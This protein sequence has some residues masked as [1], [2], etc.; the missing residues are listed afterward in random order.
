MGDFNNNDTECPT[1]SKKIHDYMGELFEIDSFEFDFYIEKNIPEK[2]K[3][4]N[5]QKM[6]QEHISGDAYIDKLM[7]WS[8]QN[9]KK[10]PNK[11]MHFT[12]MRD[13]MY[14]GEFETTS[15]ILESLHSNVLEIGVN[16]RIEEFLNTYIGRFIDYIATTYLSLCNHT[17][18]PNFLDEYL[19]ELRKV[20]ASIINTWFTE[21]ENEF[22][23]CIEFII[24][25]MRLADEIIQSIDSRIE[26]Y[27]DLIKALDVKNFNG[28]NE[29]I[30]K[31][32]K[33]NIT[34][35]QI[36]VAK[37]MAYHILISV[38]FATL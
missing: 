23:G 25:K 31:F 20:D 22:D 7:N 11:R 9:Y 32:V 4:I 1:A 2:Y 17:P 24:E 12:D 5:P 3:L 14:S 21:I 26:E 30:T 15:Y 6:I 37:K 27:I 28:N 35:R 38:L 13:K 19:K 33:T 16:F 34:S 18:P 8:N 10:N 29:Q 36:F